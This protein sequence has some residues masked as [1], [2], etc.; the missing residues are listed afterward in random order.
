[1]KKKLEVSKVLC[2][3]DYRIMILLLG[4]LIVDESRRKTEWRA[5]VG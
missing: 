3:L 4:I 5:G 2:V 1:M